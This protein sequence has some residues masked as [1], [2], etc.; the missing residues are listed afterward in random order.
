MEAFGTA[1][2][3]IQGGGVRSGEEIIE[4]PLAAKEDCKIKCVGLQTQKQHGL[5]PALSPLKL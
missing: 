5:W 1:S 4:K 3:Y 2:Q